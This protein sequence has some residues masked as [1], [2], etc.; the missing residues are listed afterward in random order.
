MEKTEGF[1]VP[2]CV[3][4]GVTSQQMHLWPE[5]FGSGGQSPEDPIKSWLPGAS[6]G[7]GK[8]QMRFGMEACLGV[9]SVDRGPVPCCWWALA[10][11][12]WC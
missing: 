1:Q 7:E 6:L 9:Q 11:Q 12:V 2:L 3:S 5:A 4:G 8:G 10:M